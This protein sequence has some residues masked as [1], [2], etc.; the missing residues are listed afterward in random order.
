MLILL[1]FVFFSCLWWS[2]FLFHTF[3]SWVLICHSAQLTREK[4]YRT[5]VQSEPWSLTVMFSILVTLSP[6]WWESSTHSK[7]FCFGHRRPCSPSVQWTCSL[8][9]RH[10]VWRRQGHCPTLMY[11][12]VSVCS[13]SYFV[14]QQMRYE[15]L[16]NFLNSKNLKNYVVVF[17][18]TNCTGN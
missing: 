1:M 16:A 4:A 5:L 7:P 18:K 8:K 13:C 17:F 10:P 9:E 14:V 3:P 2:I 11:V 6:T 12:V 15:V